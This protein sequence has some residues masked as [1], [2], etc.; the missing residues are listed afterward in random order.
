M[1]IF[2]KISQLS[3]ENRDFAVVT[4]VKSGGSAPHKPGSKMIVDDNAVK[5]KNIEPIKN[6]TNISPEPVA[7]RKNL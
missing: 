4:V 3:L 2:N 5:E 6:E 7:M 1:E